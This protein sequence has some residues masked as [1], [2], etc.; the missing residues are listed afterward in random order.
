MAD[1]SVASR[2][3][4]TTRPR[5][6]RIQVENLADRVPPGSCPPAVLDGPVRC[7]RGPRLAGSDRRATVPPATTSLVAMEGEWRVGC[8]RV[9]AR[10]RPTP[11]D[12]GKASSRTIRSRPPRSLSPRSWSN[13]GGDGAGTDRGCSPPTV[14]HARIDGITPR[15]RLGPGAG[16]R[17]ARVPRVGR[18]GSRRP[19][20]CPGHRRRRAA[21]GAAAH[22]VARGAR[23]RDVTPSRPYT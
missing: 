3:V 12:G 5:S 13:R 7:R 15:D 20:A 8:R 9:R 4:R 14:D 17:V 11:A 1:V 19:R 22:L 21:R 16:H 2:P 10:L 6:P 18:L 23:R